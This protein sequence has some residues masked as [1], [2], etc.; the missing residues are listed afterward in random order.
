M[1]QQAQVEQQGQV[2]CVYDENQQRTPDAQIFYP[3]QEPLFS[4][5]G[6]LNALQVP[7]RVSHLF[8]FKYPNMRF[9]QDGRL[10]ICKLCVEEKDKDDK[11]TGNVCAKIHYFVCFLTC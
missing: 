2:A 9:S 8:A 11:Y 5:I 6:T 7:H 4:I 3:G 10:Y 1:A